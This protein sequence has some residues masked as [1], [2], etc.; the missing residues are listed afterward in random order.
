MPSNVYWHKIEN[1]TDVGRIQEV[2]KQLLAALVEREN[3][4]LAEKIPLKVHFGEAGNVT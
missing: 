1:G 3:V 4:T 2:S